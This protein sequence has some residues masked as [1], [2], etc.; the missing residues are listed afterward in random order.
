MVD[1]ASCRACYR[2][3]VPWQRSFNELRELTLPQRYAPWL[4]CNRFSDGLSRNCGLVNILGSTPLRYTSWRLS[5][6]SRCSFAV[7]FPV[8]APVHMLS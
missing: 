7:V 5:G 2:S 8:G 3:S 1:V 4:W 6:G